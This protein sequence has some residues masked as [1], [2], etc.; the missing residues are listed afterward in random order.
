MNG[1][2]FERRKIVIKIGNARLRK[3]RI[4]IRAPQ[5]VFFDDLL[6]HISALKTFPYPDDTIVSVSDKWQLVRKV[7]TV[8]E[9]FSNWCTTSA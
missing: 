8:I 2:F 1:S 6:L 9:E 4:T 5:M 7:E 3:S